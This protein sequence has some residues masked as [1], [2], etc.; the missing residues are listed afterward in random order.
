MTATHKAVIQYTH[1]HT[2]THTLTHTPISKRGDDQSWSVTK[3]LV[4]ILELSVTDVS[5][6]VLLSL[7]PAMPQLAQPG[8]GLGILDLL[9]YQ[10]GYHITGV[11]V[12]G[13]D[14]HNLLPVS[15]AEVT[16]QQSDQCV[17]LG[18]LK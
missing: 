4:R 17:Q 7:V 10:L 3:V 1:T 18:H 13:A 14:C 16:K 15:L 2:H 12:D 5:K 11:H 9:G 8:E 6:A